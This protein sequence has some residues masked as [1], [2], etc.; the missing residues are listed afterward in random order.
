MENGSEALIQPMVVDNPDQVLGDVRRRWSS[1]DEFLD[2]FP[3]GIRFIPT[4]EE[5]VC[6]YLINKV[7]NKPMSP[8]RI[9][10]VD[11]YNYNPEQLAGT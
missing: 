10:E 2:S 8:N 9:Y 1:V 4:D 7:L 3:P 11:I 5:L 6:H